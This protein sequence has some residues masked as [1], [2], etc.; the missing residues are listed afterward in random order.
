MA[1]NTACLGCPGVA[2]PGSRFCGRGCAASFR[3][4]C[5]MCRETHGGRGRCVSRRFCSTRCFATFRRRALVP[6]V[7]RPACPRF[8]DTDS[9][10]IGCPW[11]PD[12]CYDRHCVTARDEPDCDLVLAVTKVHLERLVAYLH[13]EVRFRCD[14]P[15]KV[16]AAGAS[17]VAGARR[18]AAPPEGY[19]SAGAWYRLR[20]VRTETKAVEGMCL[21]GEAARQTA[22]EASAAAAVDSRRHYQ[23]S[24]SAS[25]VVEAEAKARTASAPPPTVEIVAAAAA[26][27]APT[28]A[29]TATTAVTTNVD[30]DGQ[31]KK[32]RKRKKNKDASTEA[33]RQ[34]RRAEHTGTKMK[35]RPSS[36]SWL[37]VVIECCMPSTPVPMVA[38]A[39]IPTVAEQCRPPADEG[40]S[41]SSGGGGGGSSSSSGKRTSE[42]P[43]PVPLP[44]PRS[45]GSACSQRQHAAVK[46]LLEDLNITRPLR[47]VYVVRG[48]VATEAELLEVLRGELQGQ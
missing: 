44:G 8:S 22:D 37:F 28:T 41:S 34:A 29:P 13:D 36:T 9:I 48:L 4:A 31:H 15:A 43:I 11:G 24:S 39:V 30:P 42:S 20:V 6:K 21:H 1:L 45:A 27:A 17:A 12:A 40:G 18:A 35:S 47:R 3:A 19:E 5:Y 46:C 38:A 32:R 16:R 2:E 10:G 14:V 23:E 33:A 7:L 26:A 25:N